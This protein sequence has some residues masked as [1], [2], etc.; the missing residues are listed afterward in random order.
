MRKQ[1]LGYPL[2]QGYIHHWLVA[3]PQVLRVEQLHRFGNPPDKLQIARQYHQAE[4]GI[5]GRPI[6]YGE[7]RIG[8]IKNNWRYVRTPHDHLIDLSAFHAAP[9]FLRAWTYTEIESPVEQEVTFLLTT[10]GPADMWINDQHVHRQE[11]FHSQMPNTVHFQVLLKDGT[12]RLMVRFEEV[13]IRECPFSM[14]LQLLGFQAGSEDKIVYIPTSV[15]APRYRL[16]MESLF[17]D[18]H[19]RQDVYTRKDQIM[20][21][22]PEGKAVT[23]PFNIRMQ[24]PGGSIYAEAARDGRRTEPQQPMGFPFQSPEG[25]YQLRFMPPPK[26]F[27]ESNIRITRT[28]DFYATPNVF[29]TQPYGTYPERRSECLKAAA[30]RRDELFGEIAK[31]EAGWWKDI[32]EKVVLKAIE[33]VQARK[34]RSVIQLCGLLSMIYRYADH[35]SFPAALHQPL[36]ECVL[37]FRYWKDEPG[38]DAMDYHS[39]SRSIL[40]H[41]CEILAGQHY[42]DRVFTNAAQPGQWHL[43]K[44]ERLA[45]EWLQKRASGGFEEWDSNTGFEEDVLALSALASLED[46]PQIFEMAALVLDKL[47]F[48]LAVNSFKGVFGSTHGRTYAAH[49]KTGYRE[50]TSGISRLLWGMGIFNEHIL[51]SVSLACSSY[52]L[53]PVIAAIAADQPDELWSKEQHSGVNK[54]TYKTPDS[55]LSSAQDWCPGQPG[56]QEHIWQATLSPV[57]TVFTSHPACASESNWRRPNYWHG[58]ASLPRVAQWKDT[59]IAIYNSAADDWMGFTHAYFPVHGMDEHEIRDGWAFG[60]VGNGYIALAAARGLAFQTHGDN[61]YRELRSSGITN[62]WLCQMG[63]LVLDGSFNE[64]VEKVLALPVKF[65][66]KQ[67]ELTT[68]RGDRL[69][70]GW[71][72]P[73]LLNGEPLP[74]GGFKHYDNPYCTCEPGAS[75]MEIRRGG[76]A[77]RLHF[78]EQDRKAEG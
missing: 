26:Q 64:F 4:I 17:E 73:L 23:T 69:H 46:N 12:N 74:L 1:T 35:E 21:Y 13:A 16:K 7:Y 8:K 65:D 40:F 36:E 70:F 66:E 30:L 55:M 5:T 29:S 22:L 71:E 58:N 25:S 28:R 31:M 78:E 19:I 72:G 50:P 3:G 51:G 47:F 38:S 59:L 56:S 39:E 45:L 49:V 62:I 6:E 43:E 11:H 18:C 9:R 57:V 52:E 75:V 15:T 68:L 67:V 14:A 76:N 53:P 63:R 33:E 44:G 61:A 60:R 32:D 37:G 41:T 54:V 34:A 10:H 20:V 77:L 48:T 2:V 27:Y 24:S 42:R